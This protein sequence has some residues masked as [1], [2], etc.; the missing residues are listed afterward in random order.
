VQGCHHLSCVMVWCEVSH[1]GVTYL[2]FCKKDL[3]LVSECINRTCY[4]EMRNSLTGPS[5]VVRNGSSSR[6]HFLPKI[7]PRGDQTSSPWTIRCG[8]FL[9]D[10]AC[11]KRHNNL[12]SLKRC[13]VKAAAEISLETVRT[14]I[15]EW[16]KRLKACVE[17]GRPL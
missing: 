1:Q 2:H 4:K 12:D 13:L 3:K 14:A 10:V 15:A 6:T 7:G 11:Q 9:E 5:S 8:L 17:G 16:P